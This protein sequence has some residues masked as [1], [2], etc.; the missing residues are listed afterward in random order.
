MRDPEVKSAALAP[1]AEMLDIAAKSVTPERAQEPVEGETPAT[2]PRRDWKLGS[3]SPGETPKAAE[4]QS[5]DAGAAKKSETTFRL[6]TGSGALATV[7][8]PI[9]GASAS[10]EKMPGKY[11]GPRLA[12]SDDETTA[13]SPAQ[14]RAL[15][16]ADALT[17]YYA[18]A[19]QQQP[20]MHTTDRAALQRIIANGKLEAPRRRGAPWS[21]SGMSRRGDVA[22]RLKPGAEQFVEFVPSTE[23]FGQVPHYYPRGVGKGSYATHIPAG[24]LEYFDLAT[25]QWAPVQRG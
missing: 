8:T 6:K 9:P 16:L 20:P 22:I 12:E 15:S 2:M 14:Q 13:N 18:K 24:H 21:M 1:T 23:I 4:S 7:D 17:E 3:P 10:A 5:G 11:Y 19:G 25:R